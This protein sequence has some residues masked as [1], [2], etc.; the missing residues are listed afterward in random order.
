MIAAAPQTV[1]SAADQEQTIKKN[2]SPPCL[3]E[4]LRRG[5]II[6]STIFMVRE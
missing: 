5:F 2:R 6:Y 1:A 3:E 4:A